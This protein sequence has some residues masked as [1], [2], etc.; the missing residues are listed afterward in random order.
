MGH[1]DEFMNTATSHGY[2]DETNLATQGGLDI[3]ATPVR[4]RGNRS[5]G[6]VLT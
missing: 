3:P 4:N 2:G 6:I 5:G 1:S